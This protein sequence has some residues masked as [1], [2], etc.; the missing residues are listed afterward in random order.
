MNHTYL[1]ANILKGFLDISFFGRNFESVAKFCDFL[2]IHF[3]AD[4]PHFFSA[5]QP[6]NS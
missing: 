4:L 3:N 6:Q 2:Q 5:S 1:V